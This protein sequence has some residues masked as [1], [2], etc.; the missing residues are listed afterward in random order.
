MKSREDWID[1]AE[2]HHCKCVQL[3]RSWWCNVSWEWCCWIF[4]VWVAQKGVW[5]L[6]TYVYVQEYNFFGEDENYS[7]PSRLTHLSG[8]IIALFLY[9][10]LAV[11]LFDS[12][13]SL[14]FVSINTDTTLAS[15]YIGQ[16]LVMSSDIM[17]VSLPVWVWWDHHCTMWCMTWVSICLS[18]PQPAQCACTHW[19]SSGA[20]VMIC[21]RSCSLPHSYVGLPEAESHAPAACA[22]VWGADAV[23]LGSLPTYQGPRTQLHRKSFPKTNSRKLSLNKSSSSGC[24]VEAKTIYFCVAS[25]EC[26]QAG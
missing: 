4:I 15:E 22:P 5:Q 23:C 9:L 13:Y 25:P 11:N 12:Y 17:S 18:C 2:Q 24:G 8:L 21:Y 1:F 19:D 3:Y 20:V 26:S 16:G 7:A 6:Q 14:S 10:F